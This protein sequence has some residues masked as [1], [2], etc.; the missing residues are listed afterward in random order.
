MTLSITTGQAA[1]LNPSTGPEAT[2]ACAFTLA[3]ASVDVMV[4]VEEA[5]GTTHVLHGAGAEGS[6]VAAPY[7]HQ[8]DDEVNF[9]ADPTKYRRI[10]LCAYDR[11]QSLYG[12][13]ATARITQPNG[14]D[15]LLSVNV[16][17]FMHA[18]V[19]AEIT[20][21]GDSLRVTMRNTPITNLDAFLCNF[22]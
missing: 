2:A 10:L 18:M 21:D 11:S 7:A 13:N 17:S 20:P 12:I 4:L 3:N 9:L 1:R 5:D 22:G 15:L 14:P 19:I 6:L 8:S 16:S